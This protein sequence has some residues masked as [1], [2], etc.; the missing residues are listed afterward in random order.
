MFVLCVNDLL[1]QLDGSPSRK[2]R[3]RSKAKWNTVFTFKWTGREPKEKLFVLCDDD[4]LLLMDLCPSRT[5]TDRSRTEGEIVSTLTTWCVAA[6]RCA[7][8]KQIDGQIKSGRRKCFYFAMMICCSWWISILKTNWWTG[9][10]DKEKLFLLCDDDLL[11]LID[12]RPVSE[13][14]DRWSSVD[15][16]N[17]ISQLCEGIWPKRLLFVDLIY[18]GIYLPELE[19]PTS[20]FWTVLNILI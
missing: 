10:E 16:T 17:F 5:F 14:I 13:L 20:D 6:D 18:F 2:W 12:V 8:F 4:L 15:F 7:S 1:P 19:T 3:D 9:G 11:A